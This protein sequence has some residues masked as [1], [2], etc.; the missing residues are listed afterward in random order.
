[1]GEEENFCC[2]V[3]LAGDLRG[4]FFTFGSGYSNGFGD[5]IRKLNVRF[6]DIFALDVQRIPV[7]DLLQLGDEPLHTHG[8]LP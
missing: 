3:F 7:P 5:S 4:N 8:S 2:S 1:M 6:Y